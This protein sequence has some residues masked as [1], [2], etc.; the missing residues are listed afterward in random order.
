MLERRR[1]R[2]ME[3]LKQSM[4][5]R[6]IARR[7]RVAVGSVISRGD[8]AVDLQVND[9]AL[10]AVAFAIHAPVPADFGPAIGLGQNAGTDADLLH[11]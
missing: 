5:V 6:E 8:S 4:A 10:D 1:L 7:L 2:A 3:F 11:F 9:H